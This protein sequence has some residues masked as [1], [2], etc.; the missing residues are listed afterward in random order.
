MKPKTQ[1]LIPCQ[2]GCGTQITRYAEVKRCSKDETKQGAILGRE[3]RY[4][5]GHA[6]K[7]EYAR[8]RSSEA[9]RGERNVNWKGGVTKSRDA[10]K[11]TLEYKAWA[12]SVYQRDRFTCRLCGERTAKPEAHHIKPVRSHPT[13]VLD[14]DN[15]ATLCGPCHELTYGKE[16]EFEELLAVHDENGVKSGDGLPGNA[17]AY[18][19]PSR[20]GNASEG[21]TTR[22]RAYPTVD[23]ERFRKHEVNCAHCGAKL[24]RHPCRM[25][26]Q[27]HFCNSTCKG[28][29][30]RTGYAGKGRKRAL[31][32]CGWCGTQLERQPWQAS[33][34]KAQYCNQQ[35]MGKA[36]ADR[37]WHGSNTPT[38]ALAE[39][40][41]IV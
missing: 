5:L 9:H 40:H 7:T 10:L 4:V 12:F 13:L 2:C 34:Y 39:T 26:Q 14:P 24:I 19:E 29:W 28:E 23:L 8:R 1:Q 35:C 32:A 21:V 20:D 6:G 18:P 17:G 15:G 36:W 27:R 38:S 22:S 3:R 30:Q 11:A 25:K 33:G 31:V 37:R 41:E 16:D